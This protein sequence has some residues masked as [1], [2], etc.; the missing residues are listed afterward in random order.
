MDK[1]RMTKNIALL[2]LV[3]LIAIVGTSSAN[4][5]ISGGTTN[6]ISN[7]KNSI[8]IGSG[9]K[10]DEE[11]PSAVASGMESVAIGNQVLSSG[12][13]SIAIGRGGTTASGMHSMAFG[14]NA[15]A[16]KNWAMAFGYNSDASGIASLSIGAKATASDKYSIAIGS[17][18]GDAGPNAVGI[19]S[20]AIGSQSATTEQYSIA[21]GFG[22][23]ADGENSTV[24]GAYN[25]AASGKGSTALGA[26]STANEASTTSLGYMS[27]AGDYH[28]YYDGGEGATALGSHSYALVKDSVAIGSYSYAV[29]QTSD[30]GVYL[31]NDENVKNTIIGNYGVVSISNPDDSPRYAFTRQL[32]GVAAGSKPTDAVNV[33]QLKGLGDAVAGIIGGNVAF[34]DASWDGKFYVGDKSYGSISEAI[35][36]MGT[37]SGGDPSPDP[38]PQ[39]GGDLTLNEGSNINISKDGN[40]YTV[41]VSDNPT[42]NKVTA[43]SI[44]AGNVS[45]S[46]SGISMGGN[47]ITGLADGGVYEGSKDAINGGQLWDAYQ[48]M[49]GMGNDIYRRMDDLREDVNI[50]GAHA[51]ALSGLH[52]IDYNPYEPTTLSAAIGTYRDEYAVAVGVFHYAKENV[53]FNLGASLC[54]DGDVMGRAGVSFTVGKSSDKPKVA[55][56]MNG[57][58]NQVIAMQAKLDELEEQNARNED[59][60]RQNMEL[61]RELK[62]ELDAKR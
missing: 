51:A 37:Q 33:A 53:M 27:F 24:I 43:N 21:L 38:T 45:M 28:G 3:L 52:P 5:E 32:T 55:G 62:A 29:R 15:N 47:K 20:I 40:E 22:A 31:L 54:S 16:V 8:A 7:L 14:D 61:I 44:N 18:E 12:N 26:G 23:N 2:A 35:A 36:D 46:Q 57:L 10:E 13:Y 41:S 19:G 34:G 39:P 17:N 4:T 60:I 59:I 56:T 1:Y 25:A 9:E 30:K 6:D 50:V 48:R 58:R 11:E 49:D 42:F